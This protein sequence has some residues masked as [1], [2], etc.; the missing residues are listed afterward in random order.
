MVLKSSDSPL[1][2]LNYHPYS[3]RVHLPKPLNLNEVWTVSLLEILENIIYQCPCKVPIKLG[4]FQDVHVYKRDTK[5]SPASFLSGEVTVT[6]VL[7]K[8][9]F[10]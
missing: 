9:P 7:R 3:F 8:L 2:H 1:F 6:L 10:F 5:S 4:Q